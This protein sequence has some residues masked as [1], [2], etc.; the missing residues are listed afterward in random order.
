MNK[1]GHSPNSDGKWQLLEDH[2]KEVA[3]MCKCFGRKVIGSDPDLNYFNGYIHD[4]FKYDDIFGRIL[5]GYKESFDH[6]G[7]IFAFLKELYIEA[8]I[9]DGHHGGLKNFRR[10]ILEMKTKVK[11][12][13][14]DKLDY[15][16]IISQISIPKSN[17]NIKLTLELELMI[18]LRFS[19]L[20]DADFLDTEKHFNK[21]KSESRNIKY[22]FNYLYE[23]LIKCI[24]KKSKDGELNISRN[25]I[26]EICIEKANLPSGSIYKL[27]VPTGLGKTLSSM[28]FAIKHLIKNNLDRIIIVAPYLSIIDQTAEIFKNIFGT[29][30]VVEH[31]SSVDYDYNDS[32]KLASENWDAPIIITT[33]VQFFESL[34]SNKPSKCRKLHNILNSVIILDEIQF[35]PSRCLKPVTDI[36]SQLAAKY[37]CTVL[38]STATQPGYQFSDFEK[39]KNLIGKDYS[40]LQRVEYKYIGKMNIDSLAER[41]KNE[42]Q[43]LVVLNIKQYALELAKKLNCFHLSANMCIAHRREI[44]KE[45]SDRLSRG[46]ECIL[47]AT[48]VVE[49]G[50]DIDFPVGYRALGPLERIMQFGG[51]IN[52]ERK[53]TKGIVYLFDFYYEEYGDQIF[54][55]KEYE[56]GYKITKKLLKNNNSMEKIIEDYYKELWYYCGFEK[57]G[58]GEKINEERKK[59]NYETVA[60]DFKIIDDKTISIVVNYKGLATGFIKSL[61]GK[62][63]RENLRKLQPFMISVS[64]NLFNEIKPNLEEIGSSGIF[65]LD[66]KYYDKYGIMR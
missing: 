51:R 43:C 10:F 27:S 4:L 56:K 44:L 8:F 13:K 20:V 61:E 6:S 5:R 1:Y 34:F 16:H 49:A 54:P 57:E 42:H 66:I 11:K 62:I 26:T 48:Q 31:H 63:S 47:I 35:L 9:M 2:L 53:L 14:M 32:R 46:E 19:C 58:L 36:L 39:G 23:E 18:R 21:F 29:N 60:N 12:F 64:K 45:V 30:C 15:Y 25:E 52:R 38:L 41:I 7:A 28:A 40:N 17:I 55:S 59:L 65:E 33:P 24:N 37:N 22:D 50:I 3:R